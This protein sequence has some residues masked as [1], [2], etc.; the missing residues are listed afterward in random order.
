MQPGKIMSNWLTILDDGI[1][2]SN[3]SYYVAISPDSILN[4][5]SSPDGVCATADSYICDT[6]IIPSVC[7]H[8]AI[9]YSSAGVKIYYNGLL[10]SG[11]YTSGSYSGNLFVSSE[12]LRIGPYILANGNLTSWYYGMLDELRI[13]TR[14]LTPS[15]I[16]ANYQN[17]LIGNETG[18]KLYYKFD[19]NITGP[20]MTVTNYATATGSA[21]NGLTYSNN[22]ASPST[23]NSCFNYL[24]VVE[25]ILGNEDLLIFPNP[26]EGKCVINTKR[27][28]NGIEIYNEIGKMVNKIS[29]LKPISLNESF[30]YRIDL[31]DYPKGIYFVKIFETEKVY[32]N[33]IILY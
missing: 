25:N 3:F 13:W 14:V 1:C 31:T 20:S 12:P 4:F 5:R 28:I 29:D 15:E 18:L 8:V 16:L 17:Q 21:L 32:T 2:N 7:L 19:I 23:I 22:A 10:Q 27:E 9:S 26:T 11:H 33:K 30:S 24:G 6:K